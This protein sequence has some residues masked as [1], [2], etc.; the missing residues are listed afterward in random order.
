MT[1]QFQFQLLD[2]YQRY[3]TIGFPSQLLSCGAPYLQSVL[4]L[5]HLSWF[6]YVCIHIWG[7]YINAQVHSGSWQ[8]LKEAVHQRDKCFLVS[9]GFLRQILFSLRKVNPA[10]CWWK[11]THVFIELGCRSERQPQYTFLATIDILKR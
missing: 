3:L 8:I 9:Y 2:R 5:I 10:I 1:Y 7:V 6:F 11:K 4:L